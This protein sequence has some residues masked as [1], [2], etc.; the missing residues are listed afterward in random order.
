[1]PVVAGRLVSILR[2][3][4]RWADAIRHTLFKKTL[5][6]NDATGSI[7]EVYFSSQDYSENRILGHSN[8]LPFLPRCRNFTQLEV[9]I[10]VDKIIAS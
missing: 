8:F 1:M 10:P 4:Y 3:N 2:S 7:F 9:E 6:T 5:L